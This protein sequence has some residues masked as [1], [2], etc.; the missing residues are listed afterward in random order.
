MEQKNS[1]WRPVSFFNSNLSI[2]EYE[3]TNGHFTKLIIKYNGEQKYSLGKSRPKAD[4]LE[5]KT[6]TKVQADG[7]TKYAK[8]M[9]V[10]LKNV[11][12][13]KVVSKLSELTVVAY[14]DAMQWIKSNRGA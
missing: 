2:T 14:Q 12:Q 7:L 10:S 11:P 1:K 5:I 13:V 6:I 9:N 3:T 4:K 8:E